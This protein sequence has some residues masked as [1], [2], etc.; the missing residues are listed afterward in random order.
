MRH[1]E[2][3]TFGQLEHGERFFHAGRL[4]TKLADDMA[5]RVPSGED[6]DGLWETFE[7]DQPVEVR[8][9][10]STDR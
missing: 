4:Y 6:D 7:A 5:Y 2:P 10:R 9:G 1:L 3:I 8:A